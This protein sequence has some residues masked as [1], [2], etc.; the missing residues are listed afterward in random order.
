MFRSPYGTTESSFCPG[1]CCQLPPEPLWDSC[2]PPGSGSHL[3]LAHGR[4]T[5]SHTG[6]I[7]PRTSCCS[8]LWAEEA[9]GVPVPA[10]GLQV[11]QELLSPTDC[12]AMSS[13]S[14][15]PT[16]AAVGKGKGTQEEWVGTPHGQARA[17]CGGSRPGWGQVC[18][19]LG[20]KALRVGEAESWELG[21]KEPYLALP[22]V[23]LKKA[24]TS[25][26]PG[27]LQPQQSPGVRQP[28][29]HLREGQAQALAEAWPSP[30]PWPQGFLLDLPFHYLG[31]DAVQDVGDAVIL[32]RERDR[33][34]W[35]SGPARA[36]RE[37]QPASVS[38]PQ[39]S[40][41]ALAHTGQG[42]SDRGK[43]HVYA[44]MPQAEFDSR[45]GQQFTERGT[46]QGPSAGMVLHWGLC[47]VRDL[48][49][50]ENGEGRPLP[51]GGLIAHTLLLHLLP[52]VLTPHCLI[53]LSP[54]GSTHLPPAFFLAAPEPLQRGAWNEGLVGEGLG[55][56]S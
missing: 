8:G 14:L 43:G 38:R 33:G 51:H 21:S 31:D 9:Q 27:L 23:L 42:R 35:G 52:N 6:R 47:R 46:G 44:L 28:G 10:P 17:C 26:R 30:Q 16:Q 29:L 7:P 4:G 25:L 12:L 20:L 48:C 1:L 41:W 19:G 50:G 56:W 22:P 15:T 5:Y 49:Q 18:L 37:G 13:E 11:P 45:G 2:P 3:P 34:A 54:P 24:E 36:Y 40:L 32:R 55:A 39:S 53:S